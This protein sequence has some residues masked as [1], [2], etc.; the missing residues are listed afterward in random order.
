MKKTGF[1][2]DESYFWHDNGSG[3]LMLRTGGWIEAEVYGE[4]PSTKR[5]VKNLLEKTKFIKELK[6]IEP[7]EA[8][9]EEIL[10]VHQ[11]DYMDR[12]KMLSDSTGGD[13]GIVAVV[14]PGS[15]EI[16]ML[17]A[18]GAIT[19]V[20]AV[21]NGDVQNV[22]A[23]TRPPGHHATNETGM[24]F[25]IFNN[26]AVAAKFARNEYGVKRIL[27]V[28]WDVHHGN[29]TEAI[30]YDDPDLLFVSLHQEYNFP[31]D[32]GFAKDVGHGEGEGYNVNIPLPAGTGDAGYLYAFEKVIEPIADQFKPELILIS[33]GQDASPFDPLAQMMVTADG[34][35]KMAAKMKAI[36]ERHCEGRLVVCHEGGYSAA[37]VPFCTLRIIEAL[38]GLQ[39][40][41]TEDPYYEAALQGL[42]SGVL[43]PHQ[44]EAVD[45]VVE[46][47]SKYWEL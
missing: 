16:A 4:S 28:D 31:P 6:E 14:G 19:G 9:R 33:A 18:G 40:K 46:I 1:I 15:Y 45:H 13:A 3:A 34:Y 37:Y 10:A 11:V 38:S 26:V 17:S 12:V 36:A 23:L 44:K 7:R 25:C 8:T 20:E 41:V 30:F 39:S 27:V 24:G 35:G 42:P 2:S 43:A 5:R 32:R 29:G 21:M 22:Y 47:Q